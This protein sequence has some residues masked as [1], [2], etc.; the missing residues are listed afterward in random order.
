MY[1]NLRIHF[2]KGALMPTEAKIYVNGINADT[3]QYMLK[4]MTYKQV[5]PYIIGEK[6]DKGVIGWLK[7]IW[8]SF[9]SFGLGFE[10]DWTNLADVG[11]GLVF[12]QGE[13]QAVRAAIE[14]LFQHR[15]AQVGDDNLI[16]KLE[17]RSGETWEAFLGRY[18]AG[19]GSI[20]PRKVPFYLLL[21]GSPEYISFPIGYLLDVKFAVG[22]LDFDSPESYSAY[23]SSVI[24]YEKA[25]SVP[26]AR[27]AVFF[28]TRH[29]F[30]PA[31]NLS[32]DRL[33]TPLVDGLPGEPAVAQSLGFQS[34]KLVEKDATRAALTQV[35]APPPGVKPPAFLFTASHGMV[36]PV[37]KPAE[38]RASQGALLCQDWPG[39][40]RIAPEHYFSASDLPADARLQ[41][42]ITFHFACHS[43]GTPLED[44][45]IHETHVKPPQIAPSPFI[46]SLPKTLLSHSNGGSL[47][48]IGHVERAWG[49]SIFT[50]EAGDQISP[51]RS[52]IGYI[53][54]GLPVGYAVKDLNMRNAEY[55][56]NLANLLQ[57]IH[58]GA[59]IPDQEL[60][61]AWIKR[62]DSEGYII[63]GDPAV[64]L[65]VKDLT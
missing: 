39:F 20:D 12:H 22:R 34:K 29:Q 1:L 14:P 7:N 46:A 38:Q 50:P 31:T 27:T 2:E 25:A 36:W 53:L 26:N 56:V 65:R 58:Q 21:V 11:W 6:A 37:S 16:K 24:D 48:V 63:V 42:M 9:S 10:Y 41:G 61:S 40:G 8:S 15:R 13:S 59:V 28:G 35:L 54:N 45:F 64:H 43:A 55:S 5:I 47:A 44:R 18:G 23:V 4:P 51:F 19:I 62:N 52:T 60:A 57:T 49:T 32:A 17:Y 33:V 30:D 3:G